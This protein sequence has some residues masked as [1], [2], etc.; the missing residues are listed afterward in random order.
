MT[1]VKY[2]GV[3]PMG[4]MRPRRMWRPGEVLEVE[5]EVAKELLESRRFT[6]VR[7]RRKT[8]KKPEEEPEEE[9]EEKTEKKLEEKETAEEE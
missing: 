7:T 1:R 5:D 4:T 9:P 2:T 3:R 8:I 6:T